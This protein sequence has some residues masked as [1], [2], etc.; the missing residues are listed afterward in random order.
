MWHILSSFRKVVNYLV[1][2]NLKKNGYLLVRQ[3]FYRLGEQK[4]GGTIVSSVE[5]MLKLIRMDVIQMIE[6][7]RLNNHDVIALFQKTA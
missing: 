3:T 2:N 7:N 6:L 4:H 5:D 1:K